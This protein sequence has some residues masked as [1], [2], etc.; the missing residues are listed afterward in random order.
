MLLEVVQGR[1]MPKLDLFGSPLMWPTFLGGGVLAH[2][3]GYSHIPYLSYVFFSL[4]V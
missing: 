1:R 4:S 2:Y 3:D